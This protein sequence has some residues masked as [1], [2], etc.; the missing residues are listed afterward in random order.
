MLYDVIFTYLMIVSYTDTIK[1]RIPNAVTYP[2]AAFGLFALMLFHNDDS[3]YRVLMMV[4]IFFMGY[5]SGG[6]IGH[7]DIKM[8]M[9]LSLYMPPSVLLQI[10][11]MANILIVVRAT[12][13]DARKT[14]NDFKNVLLKLFGVRKNDSGGKEKVPFAPYMLFAFMIYV[15]YIAMGGA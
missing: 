15:A 1:K 10:F 3:V 12:V 2:F 13:K 8:L 4:P 11:L 14:G 9:T 6:G 7:G 5:F